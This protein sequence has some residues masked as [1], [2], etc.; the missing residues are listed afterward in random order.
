MI[1]VAPGVIAATATPFLLPR[2]RP[3]ISNL[4][5]L[6]GYSLV[7]MAVALASLEIGLKQAPQDG[8]LSPLCLA[9]LLLSAA[10]ATIF[11]SRTLKARHPVVDLSTLKTRSFAIG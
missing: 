5:T 4:V 1:N 11:A 7:L 6:D 2:G 3:R 8:W 9:P 10:S